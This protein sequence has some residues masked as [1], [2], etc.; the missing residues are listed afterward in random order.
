MQ[1]IC[2]HGAADEALLIALGKL[3]F[4]TA[5]LDVMLSAAFSLLQGNGGSELGDFH[6]RMIG[7]KAKDIEVLARE[8]GDETAV[9]LAQ[10]AIAIIES[11]NRLI[12]GI[13]GFEADNFEKRVLVRQK[14]K[15]PEFV[16]PRTAKDV[17]TLLDELGELCGLILQWS[18]DNGGRFIEPA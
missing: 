11:R 4:D 7:N 14:G 2:F 15:V 6:G 12:H 13:E 1:K 8:K 3:V 9:T 16:V 18:R 17:E 10:R 5:G